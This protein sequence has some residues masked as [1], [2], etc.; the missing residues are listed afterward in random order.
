MNTT[1][2]TTIAAIATPPGIGGVGIVRVSGPLARSIALGVVGDI[3]KPREATLAV[4]KDELGRAIDQGLAIY[5]PGPHSFTGEDVLELQGHGGQA[6]LQAILKRVYALGAQ[7]SKPGEFTERAFLNDKMDLSQAEAVSDLIHATTEQAAR[8]AMRSLSGVFSK[9]VTALHD[10]L[11]RLRVFV[12]AAIDFPD[13]D[14]EFI[15]SEQI[16]EQLNEIQ[17]QVDQ[18]KRQS[19]RGLIL[20]RG[21]TA[22]IVGKPNAGKSSLLNLL[23]GDDIAIVTD[24]PGT[25]RDLIQTKIAI[26]GIPLYIIDTAGLRETTDVV[27]QMGVEK[28]LSTIKTADLILCVVDSTQPNEPLPELQNVDPE[29]CIYLYNKKDLLAPNNIHADAL[30]ISAK[31]GEGTEALYD[32]LRKRLTFEDVSDDV[33]SARARHLSAIVTASDALQSGVQ[34]LAHGSIELLAQELREAHDALG[35]IVGK[36][37]SDDMLGEIFSSFCIGK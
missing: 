12:E 32:A 29:K 15:Q 8:A 34:Q 17:A 19:E 3:P 28:A 6:V 23:A 24:I 33:C 10:T 25:T 20:S 21:L 13:E 27:E 7:P 35:S 36:M 2:N 18:L 37:T 4:F 9:K 1:P 11:I 22:V 26:D 5:F 14:I 16:G 31:T 30:Y